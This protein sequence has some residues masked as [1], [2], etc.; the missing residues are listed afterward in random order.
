M[1]TSLLLM[2]GLA[3]AA[4]PEKQTLPV[5]M[6]SLST[7]PAHVRIDGNRLFISGFHSGKLVAVNSS[8]K[9]RAKQLPLDSHETY[10]IGEAGQE[11]REI[12]KGTGGDL[13]LA[14]GKI[15]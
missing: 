12:R 5:R 13:A 15:F 7:D 11:I 8:G 2:A 1:T 10:R 6:L 4:E 3:L 14:A 9:K